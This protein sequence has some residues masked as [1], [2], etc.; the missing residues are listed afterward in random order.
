MNSL[1]PFLASFLSDRHPDAWLDRAVAEG[2]ALCGRSSNEAKQIALALEFAAYAHEGLVRKYTEEPYIVHPIA[3]AKAVC[4]VYPD[5]DAICAALLHDTIEDTS[6]TY[7]D[8]RRLFGTAIASLV[9]DLTDVSRKPEDGNRAARKAIDRAHTAKA[10]PVAKLVK[11]ADLNNNWTSISEHDP[12]FAKVYRQEKRLLLDESLV[13][14]AEPETRLHAAF[15]TLRTRSLALLDSPE[16]SLDKT[17]S[18][19]RR[20][21]GDACGP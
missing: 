19:H 5:A 3:V 17:P 2:I 7:D 10:V 18:E 6:T 14:P 8:I 15:E 20:R 4:A 1:S 13:Q 12:D 16:S 9:D 11:L 21:R